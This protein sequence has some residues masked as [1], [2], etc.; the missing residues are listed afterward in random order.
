MKAHDL[1]AYFTKKIAKPILFAVSDPDSGR[2]AE[3]N[4]TIEPVA[5]SENV[6]T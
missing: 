1:A 2:G 5:V 4:F 3:L 6:L